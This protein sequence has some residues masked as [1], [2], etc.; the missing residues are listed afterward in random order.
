MSE[1]ISIL[2]GR[3]VGLN[4]CTAGTQS[5]GL[6]I[7]TAGTQSVGLNIDIDGWQCRI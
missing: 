3:S 7:D 4:I 5:V 1:L 2:L 6:N